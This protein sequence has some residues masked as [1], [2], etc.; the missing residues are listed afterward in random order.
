MHCLERYLNTTKVVF[1]INNRTENKLILRAKQRHA[2]HFYGVKNISNKGNKEKLLH[3]TLPTE[4]KIT[5]VINL[6]I[7][8]IR[9]DE[10]TVR[11]RFLTRHCKGKSGSGT[12]VPSFPSSRVK[13]IVS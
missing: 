8:A 3:G 9:S 10:N 4:L 2:V 7:A 6:P 5:S 13:N 11:I 1:E 12:N